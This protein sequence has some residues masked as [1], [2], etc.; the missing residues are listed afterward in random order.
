MSL[1]QPMQTG[2]VPFPCHFLLSSAS[3]RSNLLLTKEIL[4]SL[5]KSVGGAGEGDKTAM[6]KGVCCQD[7]Q[8]EF[9]PWPYMVK[10]ALTPFS[11]LS[12]SRGSQ[13]T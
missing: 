3:K 9:N 7:F 12:D 13:N 5:K 1:A 11:R 2:Q 10:R 8:H 6:G 4:L